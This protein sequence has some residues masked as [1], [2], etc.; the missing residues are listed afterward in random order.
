MT[1]PCP[2][3]GTYVS[4]D[5]ILDSILKS[6]VKAGNRRA[7]ILIGGCSQ[8][9]KTTLANR[10]QRDLNGKG[11]E[12]CVICLDSWIKDI[13]LRTGEE[14]VRERYS[15]EAIVT[16][17]KRLLAGYSIQ[18]PFYDSKTRRVICKHDG[19]SLKLGEGGVAIVEGVVALDIEALRNIAD[20]KVFVDIG[21]E[22]RKERVMLFY[23][24]H[25]GCRSEEAKRIVESREQ[26]EVPIIK[27]SM[28]FANHIYSGEDFRL[29]R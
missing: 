11:V 26:E 23:T 20:Q 3:Y 7:V 12:C 22:I 19:P 17:I 2:L 13:R 16:H 15:Y 8:S 25:K 10:L 14:T 18:L 29:R 6:Q 24:G 5:R 21:D 9:G 1:G 28:A 4:Y 27:A